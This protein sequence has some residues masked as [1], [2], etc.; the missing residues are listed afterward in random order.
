M[1]TVIETF[2]LQKYV[3]APCEDD[4][5]AWAKEEGP[6][7]KEG[8]KVSNKVSIYDHVLFE[9]EWLDVPTIGGGLCEEGPA[10]CEDGALYEEGPPATDIRSVTFV[11]EAHDDVQHVNLTHWTAES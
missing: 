5:A 9:D 3:F 4:P 7:R 2:N 6:I 10:G 8:V 11:S 1:I